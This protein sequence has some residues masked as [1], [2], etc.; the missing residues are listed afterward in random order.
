MSNEKLTMQQL[1]IRAT[2]LA[3]KS[4]TSERFFQTERGFHGR[5]Y[6]ALQYQ[7]DQENLFLD[8]AILEMEYQKSVRHEM[9]QRPDI[10]FHVP[11]EYSNASV[12]TNNFA[13]W[14]LKRKS[15]KADALEDFEKLDQMIKYLH[16]P[17]GFFINIDS[18][19][20]MQ[21]HYNGEHTDKLC[22]VAV[23]LVE[24]NVEIYW[25][26]IEKA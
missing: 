26:N 7:L 16:Y 24:S 2:E 6:C 25:G 21:N 17:M 14:A 5:F 22:A 23:R 10:I 3:L 1:I 8:G 15:S 9:N 11:A 12:K 4:V 13:V 20:H 19:E 18:N